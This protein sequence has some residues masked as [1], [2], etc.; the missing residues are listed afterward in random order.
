[1]KKILP[2]LFST[3]DLHYK[4]ALSSR[5]HKEGMD[6]RLISYQNV[7]GKDWI[8]TKYK[9]IFFIFVSSLQKKNI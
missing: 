3:L 9:Q 1:M 6:E 2:D 7:A 4:V 8:K 5:Q